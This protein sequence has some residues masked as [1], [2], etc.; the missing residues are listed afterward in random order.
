MDERVVYA[1]LP[2]FS[3]AKVRRTVYQQDTD[4]SDQQAIRDIRELVARGWLVPTAR[5][6]PAPTPQAPS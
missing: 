6:E 5:P 3:D 2:A 1:L 4:L